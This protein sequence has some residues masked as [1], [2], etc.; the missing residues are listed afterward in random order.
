MAEDRCEYPGGGGVRIPCWVRTQDSVASRSRRGKSLVM[1]GLIAVGLAACGG[2]PSTSPPVAQAQVPGA[3][4]VYPPIPA[5]GPGTTEGCL[6]R[7][8]THMTMQQ[9][10]E[11]LE[12]VAKAAGTEL[13]NESACPNGP[14]VV[15]LNPGNEA[16]AHQIWTRFGTDIAI[17]IG[18][19]VYDGTPG[20]SP[21]CGTLRPS[22]PDPDG[23]RFILRL[24]SQRVESGGQFGGSVVITESGPGAFFM[25]T[26]QP[27]QA[28]VV[29]RNTREVVGVFSG[30]IGG[31]GYAKRL[32][33]G[34]SESIDVIGGTARCDGGVGS[35]LPP[36]R[37]QAF[38][39]VS[40]ETSP[41]SPSY[42]TPPVALRVNSA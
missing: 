29:K 31:T 22:M 9:Q 42:G 1:C 25:D 19:T 28:V 34:Q 3:T 30:A 37:Y 35:A 24:K 40:P 26:G 2:A 8:S 16:I 23:L 7:K 17:S 27:L 36:G 39:E 15:G 18:L 38:V 12:Y 32:S 20:R 13:S 33:A 11:I 21:R 5:F 14:V 6:G 41:H 4:S 10:Q